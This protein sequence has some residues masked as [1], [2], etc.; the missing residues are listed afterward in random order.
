[1]VA[2][3]S[4]NATTTHTTVTVRTVDKLATA[5]QQARAGTIVDIADGT[6]SLDRPLVITGQGT[7]QHLIVI[8]A[9]NRGKVRIVGTA[10]LRLR[11][12]VWV[13]ID[14]LRLEPTVDTGQAGVHVINSAHVR[15]TRLAFH[16][17]EPHGRRSPVTHWLSFQ[18][19]QHSRID[20]SVF[21]KR[22][23]RGVDIE[24]RKPSQHIRI[25]HN[26]F[27]DRETHGL[28]G[29]ETIRVDGGK[30]HRWDTHTV[31]E[32]NLFDR[33]NGEGE[34]ISIK[35]HHN[36]IR[37]NTFRES[38]GG[39]SIRGGDYNRIEGNFFLAFTEPMAYAVRLH[40][41]HNT[42]INNYMHGLERCL[43]SSWGD[44]HIPH[45]S[46]T[47]RVAIRDE[48][49]SN[50]HE[51][52]YRASYH[53]T[54]AFNTMVACDAVFTWFKRSLNRLDMRVPR[55]IGRAVNL[56]PAHW[57][58]ANNL[59]VNAHRFVAGFV[60]GDIPSGETVEPVVEHGF[61]WSGNMI[62][63]D[64]GAVDFGPGRV[65]SSHQWHRVDPQL[66]ASEYRGVLRLS[67]K[68]PAIGQAVGHFP[69]VIHDIEG[70]ARQGSKDVGADEYHPDPAGPWRPLTPED[71]GPRSGAQPVSHAP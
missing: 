40:G 47:E 46:A 3:I 21:G 6:Y 71:V 27:H 2:A 60:N 62:F 67:K 29:A 7:K 9:I 64:Q 16:F 18:A 51:A 42:V 25:D 53:N 55:H 10:T 45:I 13:M 56:P 31:I 14:G 32:H 24:V 28:N 26:Y 59:V 30:G 33:C 43:I 20:H 58:V 48:D 44:T 12:A 36:T 54:I 69:G 61:R 1:V 68:S 49:N 50:V 65:F 70:Q 11:G 8:R 5:V 19:T 52:H 17:Q 22:V 4:S 41:L 57:T 15:L 39:V 37:A 66:V 63:R 23:G 35:S 38:F 34:I